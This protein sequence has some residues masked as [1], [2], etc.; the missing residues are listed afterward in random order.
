MSHQNLPLNF[1]RIRPISPRLLD[2]AGDI[3]A[4]RGVVDRQRP[5]DRFDAGELRDARVGHHAQRGEGGFGDAVE[6]LAVVLVADRAHGDA[7]RRHLELHL[8]HRGHHVGELRPAERAVQHRHVV[9][10]DH[11]LEMLQPVAGDD[12]R[13]AAAD[14][15]VVGLDELAVVHL[16]QA[17]VARQ[18]RLFLGRSHIGED[19]PVAFLDRIPGLAHLVLELAA[20][21]LAG[22]LQAMALGVELPA[23]IAAADA[24]FLDLAVIERGAAVAAARMQQAGAAVPVA[25]QDQVLA[26]RADF[27]GDIGGVGRRGRPG[28]SSA[29]AVRPSAC[30]GR[31]RSVRSG[32][33][34]GFMA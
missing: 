9:G 3:D 26:E 6:H 15:G 11:V 28:A 14:R 10:V 18:H 22:L 2:P 21:G 24:V 13:A 7:A 29:A 32:W 19:Q 23:V 20:V 1:E 33:L 31:P 17:F 5:A 27:A 8:R 34:D 12:G 4:E 25:E 30:R 16:L